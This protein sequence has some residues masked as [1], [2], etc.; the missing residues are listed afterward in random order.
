MK[1]FCKPI[2]TIDPQIYPANSKDVR[3]RIDIN[4][5]EDVYNIVRNKK[6]TM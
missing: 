2:Y 4:P 6:K 3:Q 5:E 1:R